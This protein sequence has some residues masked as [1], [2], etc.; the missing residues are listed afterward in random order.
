MKI[1]VVEDNPADATLVRHMLEAIPDQQFTIVGASTLKDGMGQLTEDAFDLVL[2]DLRLPDSEGMETFQKL[3]QHS[4][5]VPVVVLTGIYD[6]ALAVKAVEGGAQDYLVKGQVTGDDLVRSI[7]YSMLRAGVQEKML[8]ERGLANRGKVIGFIGAKGGVGTTTTALNLTSSLIRRGKSGIIL[9]LRNHYGTLAAQLGAT[10]M[11]NLSQ[12]CGLSAKEISE[13]QLNA[14]LCA[15][16]SGLRALY[17]PQ[18][19]DE[20]S[21]LHPDQIQAMIEGLAMMTDYVLVDMCSYPSPE[22]QA[23]VQHCNLVVLAVTADLPCVSAGKVY[24]HLLEKWGVEYTRIAAIIINHTG[25]SAGGMMMQD[26]STELGCRIIGVVTPISEETIL[27][28]RKHGVPVV[29][30]QPDC[31]AASNLADI[32]QRI[33]AESN[34]PIL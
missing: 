27:S 14:R 22:N 31:M 29:E 5:T 6:E 28:A 17:G 2:L 19:V 34:P 25:I 26:V 3:H 12:L 1:L 8:R 24:L 16:S 23:A 18:K 7:R 32:A 33:T 9:E 4:P 30:Y 21:E 11:T 13:K 10:P 15:V 20:F